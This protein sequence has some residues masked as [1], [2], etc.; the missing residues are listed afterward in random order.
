MVDTL[1]KYLEENCFHLTT[2]FLGTPYLCHVLSRNGR[3]DVAYKILIQTDYISWGYQIIKGA[4]T[5]WEHWDGIKSDGSFWNANINSFNHYAYG[6]IGDWM[7][8]VIA[9]LD[10]D[11]EKHAIIKPQSGGSLRFASAELK[12]MYGIIK[13]AWQI[14]DS[15][16][17]VNLVIPHNTTATVTLPGAKIESLMEN[18]RPISSTEFSSKC[19]ES[20]EGVVIE[21]LSGE[22]TFTY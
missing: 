11:E 9:G 15:A 1:V 20:D 2:G 14:E 5:I 22:Y 19:R 7:Y 18:G 13:S 12:S 10:T 21:L 16:M 8:R 6:A 4:T 3:A 17:R